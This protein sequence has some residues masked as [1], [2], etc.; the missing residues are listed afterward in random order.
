MKVRTPYNTALKSEKITPC[1]RVTF[2]ST[3]KG[4]VFYHDVCYP[5]SSLIT[6]YIANRAGCIYSE[7]AWRDGY[8]K[9]KE[10]AGVFNDSSYIDYWTGV[11]SMINTLSLPAFI[12][13]SKTFADFAC[14]NYTNKIRLNGYDV[15]LAVWNYSVVS[16]YTTTELLKILGEKFN[17]VYDFSCGYG[18]ALRNFEYC[19]GSDIDAACLEYVSREILHGRS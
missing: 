16:A 11:K 4:V 19:I 1:G 9:F 8:P 17:S 15:L 14:P 5:L 12:P 3:N 13:C 7:I 2:S 18:N 6:Y 10:R